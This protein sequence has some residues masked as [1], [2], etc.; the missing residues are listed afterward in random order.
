MDIQANGTKSSVK[1]KYFIREKVS[2]KLYYGIELRKE[3]ELSKKYLLTLTQHFLK[4][5]AN[6]F[7]RVKIFCVA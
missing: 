7:L 2:A 5:Q 4:I 1:F 6:Y 3:V